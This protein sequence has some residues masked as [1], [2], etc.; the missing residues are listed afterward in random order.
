MKKFYMTMAA[1]LCGVAA[2]AQNALYSE[3]IKVDAGEESAEIEIFMMN[4]VDVTACSFR[5]YFPDGVYMPYDGEDYEDE[6]SID[7]TR[8]KK[9]QAI[10][11]KSEDGGDMISI[12]HSKNAVISGND[13]LLVTVPFVI[14]PNVQEGT[15]TIRVTNCSMATP[16]KVS[17]EIPTEFDVTL[18]IGEGT[19]INGINAN[20]SK[21][22]IY[23]VAGQRV[24]KAQKGVFIQNG[25]KVAVK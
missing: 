12:Y 7:K 19:G 8:A 16:D 6:V 22:P 15:Y 20:D 9:H 4:E 5:L 23:N 2:M 17:L 25:K 13:G 10:M 11:Q 1:M 21:A 24:S 3:D 14:S 18:Q